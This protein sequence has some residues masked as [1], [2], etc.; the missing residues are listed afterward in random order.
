MLMIDG[1]PLIGRQCSTLADAL[2]VSTA[3]R[4]DTVRTATSFPT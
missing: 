3:W 2:G 4:Q 1:E